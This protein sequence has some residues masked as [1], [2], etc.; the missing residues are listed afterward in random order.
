MLF[1]T[2]L[3]AGYLLG[4]RLP[5]PPV[6]VV[7]GAA[8]PDLVDKPLAMAGAVDLF[9]TVGHSALAAAALGVL[10]LRSRAALALW[11]GWAS[12]LALDA[13]GMVLNGR[14]ADVQFLLWPAVRHTPAVRLPP[15]EFA[16]AYV[17]TP[18]FFLEGLV[19]VA[20]LWVLADETYF[21]PLSQ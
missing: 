1:P 4:H 14:P 18:A 15:V 9:H 21:S 20:V 16:L 8:L 10:A 7:A 2:H 6:P 13:F 3:A 12:H 11:V 19:W 17:G 5:L